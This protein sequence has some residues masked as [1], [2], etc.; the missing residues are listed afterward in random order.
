[1][2]LERAVPSAIIAGL[3]GVSVM[4]WMAIGLD[5]DHGTAFADTRNEH[6]QIDLTDPIDQQVRNESEQPWITNVLW[7]HHRLP[8]FVHGKDPT[9]PVGMANGEKFEDFKPEEEFNRAFN[10]FHSLQATTRAA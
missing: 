1:V 3:L 7:L 6:R 8:I 2:V 4:P 10:F 5:Y 9:F